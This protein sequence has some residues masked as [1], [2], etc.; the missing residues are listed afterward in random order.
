MDENFIFQITTNPLNLSKLAE[1]VQ[2]LFRLG[3]LTT[4]VVGLLVLVNS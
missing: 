3:E 2:T 1:N 4:A